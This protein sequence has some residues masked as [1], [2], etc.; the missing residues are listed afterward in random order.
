M[1]D[2]LSPTAIPLSSSSSLH[3][4]MLITQ[5]RLG[6]A[7]SIGIDVQQRRQIQ[8]CYERCTYWMWFFH[9]KRVDQYRHKRAKT[10]KLS[11]TRGRIQPANKII[12]IEHRY[13]QANIKHN[14][15]ASKTIT[16]GFVKEYMDGLLSKNLMWQGPGKD[17]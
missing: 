9:I 3:V 7:I 12:K 6:L 17:R 8:R 14:K 4:P 5:S 16:N 11:T 1:Q 2:K 13:I 10:L 15:V